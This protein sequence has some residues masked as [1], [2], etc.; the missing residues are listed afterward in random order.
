VPQIA[1]GVQQLED[2]LRQPVPPPAAER[3]YMVP[4]GG[5]GEEPAVP[6]AVPVPTPIAKVIAD[7]R[8]VVEEAAEAVSTALTPNQKRQRKHA[9]QLLASVVDT[10][11]DQIAFRRACEAKLP[12]LLEAIVTLDNPLVV[13]RIVMKRPTAYGTRDSPTPRRR[14]EDPPP[15]EV[16]EEK[17]ARKRDEEVEDEQQELVDTF[18]RQCGDAGTPRSPRFTHPVLLQMGRTIPSR[19]GDVG[20]PDATSRRGTIELCVC[21]HSLRAWDRCS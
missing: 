5:G 8:V 11:P 6:A 2:A 7:V 1:A 10:L 17:E 21:A 12:L 13:A 20:S 4:R 18:S 9:A 15:A 3:K 16:D 19:Q 14:V